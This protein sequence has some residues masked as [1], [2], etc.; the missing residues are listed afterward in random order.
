MTGRTQNSALVT[1]YRSDSDRPRRSFSHVSMAKRDLTQCKKAV[2]PRLHA[3]GLGLF[4]A[5]AAAP[6]A[7][8]QTPTVLEFL[9]GGDLLNLSNQDQF[10]AQS[11]V[12]GVVD[13]SLAAGTMGIGANPGAAKIC[14]PGHATQADLYGTVIQYITNHTDAQ[15]FPAAADVGIALGQVYPCGNE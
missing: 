7:T 10:A 14:L 15:Q 1:E 6:I 5:A 13:A 9:N 11:Y 2:G 8:A 4:L 12:T 3:I